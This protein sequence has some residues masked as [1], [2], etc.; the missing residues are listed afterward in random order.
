VQAP[1]DSALGENLERERENA[2]IKQLKTT[3]SRLR[4]QHIILHMIP[5]ALGAMFSN[6]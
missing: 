1:Q 2:T 5:E 3:I 6:T 4:M